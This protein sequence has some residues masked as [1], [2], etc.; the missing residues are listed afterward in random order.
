ME[1]MADE[2]KLMECRMRRRRGRRGGGGEGYGLLRTILFSFPSS[3]SLL[4]CMV[5]VSVC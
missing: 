5:G 2:E 4:W 1:K 3:V